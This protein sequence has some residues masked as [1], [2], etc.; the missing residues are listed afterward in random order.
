[1]LWVL[2]RTISMRGSVGTQKNRLDER[3]CGYSKEPSRKIIT[4]L[5][6][7]KWLNE[8]GHEFEL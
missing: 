1:M 4:I 6:Y 3:V 2:K 8:W 5:L 7:K